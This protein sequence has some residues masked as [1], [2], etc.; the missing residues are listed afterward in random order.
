MKLDMANM[1]KMR[2]YRI[3]ISIHIPDFLQWKH[4]HVAFG[5]IIFKYYLNILVRMYIAY[6]KTLANN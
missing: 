3:Q 6:Y 5:K 1:S 4:E 2:T